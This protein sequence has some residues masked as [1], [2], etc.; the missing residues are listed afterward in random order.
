MKNPLPHFRLQT[1][2][3]RL[4]DG[5]ITLS[6]PA[7]AI[8]GIIAGVDLLTGGH[9]LQSVGWLSVTWAVCLLLTLDFQV[10][11][12]GVK[13]QTIYQSKEKT[14]WQKAGELL[15]VLAVAAAISYVSIQMQ[16][17]I[18]RSSSANVSINQ[19]SLDLGVNPIALIWE[20]SILV[21]LLIFLSGWSRDRRSVT[22]VK[23]QGQ[24][25]DLIAEIVA[26]LT[27]LQQDFFAQLTRSSEGAL[28]R[29]LD[30]LTRSTQESL[31]QILNRVNEEQRVNTMQ[32]ADRVNQNNQAVLATS[33]D[34]LQ[35]AHKAALADCIR[36][37]EQAHARRFEAVLTQV[38]QVRVTLEDVVQ[39]TA[40][41]PAIRPTSVPQLLPGRG[42][43]PEG[44]TGS[45]E[46]STREQSLGSLTPAQGTQGSVP[47]GLNSGVT[48]PAQGST[49]PGSGEGHLTGKGVAV[50]MFIASY[51]ASQGSL[52]GVKT[53][54]AEAHCARN[55]A[56]FYLRQA[57][58]SETP[59]VDE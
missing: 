8:S 56:R 28:T 58:S 9:M 4:E 39:N 15:L 43:Q 11:T 3:H 12:L 14:G 46:S 17:V 25:D 1:G 26:Q 45:V 29:S 52:P 41:M 51:L 34:Q 6:G 38:K 2:V 53:V 54:M 33:L 7:L 13:A 22:P 57:G 44:T 23:G 24:W 48:D 16:S 55:T 5:I 19:A 40:Q 37:L 10:L 35:Q 32:L 20:R 50:Q 59:E 42:Q 30:T 18:A 49:A 31:A 21:L 36:D 27:P 47:G